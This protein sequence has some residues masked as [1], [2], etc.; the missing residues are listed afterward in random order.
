MVST[1]HVTGDP[2]QPVVSEVVR[3]FDVDVSILGGSIENLAGGAVG[4]LRVSLSG[5][6]QAAAL[7]YLRAQG[8]AL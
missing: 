2:H 3:K 1:C 7:A 4:R 8:V 6:E 5:D